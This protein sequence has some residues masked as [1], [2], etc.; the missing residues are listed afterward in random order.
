MSL[1]EHSCSRD[2]NDDMVIINKLQSRGL[3]VH[4]IRPEPLQ[5]CFQN[6]HCLRECISTS[7]TEPL[8]FLIHKD[9]HKLVQKHQ[10]EGTISSI[11]THC[12]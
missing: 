8:L 9:T 7:H 2:R 10:E 3:A 5:S 4:Q 1:Q 12:K 11:T 6:H